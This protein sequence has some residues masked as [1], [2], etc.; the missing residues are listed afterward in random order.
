MLCCQLPNLTNIVVPLLQSQPCETQGG[1][2]T[3]P[4]LLGQSHRKLVQHLTVVAPQSSK[5][6]SIAIHNQEAI[7]VIILQQSCERCSVELVVAMVNILVD[8][9]EGLEVETQFLL[10]SLQSLDFPAI[11]DETILRSL[12]IKL[13]A[14]LHRGD[15]RKY[16]SPCNTRFYGCSRAK[17]LSQEFVGHID[18][19][20]GFEHQGYHRCAMTLRPIQCLNQSPYLELLNG[21]L[22][23]DWHGRWRL[24]GPIAMQSC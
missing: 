2:A 6:C 5:Q 23:T 17:L 19:V 20:L 10:P 24:G 9:L 13:Q 7:G 3:A 12:A 21:C 4:M 18:V 11:D 14:L 8:W 16:R 22:F 15:G 1:L